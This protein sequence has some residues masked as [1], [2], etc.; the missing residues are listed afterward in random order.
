MFKTSAYLSEETTGRYKS[1]KNYY[2]LFAVVLL[3]SGAVL[4]LLPVARAAGPFVL[5]AGWLLLFDMILSFLRP[6]LYSRG[7]ADVVMGIVSGLYYGLVSWSVSG[8]SI[9]EIEGFRIFI[10]LFL[11][12]TGVARIMEFARMTSVKVLP[13]TLICGAADIAVAALLFAG[14]PGGNTRMICWYLGMLAVLG[15]FSYLGESYWL[16]SYLQKKR[17]M[18]VIR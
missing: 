12:F 13:V 5:A 18:S 11:I 8:V 3:A 1:E 7:M 15:G 2:I 17:I 16:K 10:S 4:L 9:S 14:V 6:V